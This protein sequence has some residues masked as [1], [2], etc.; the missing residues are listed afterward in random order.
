MAQSL[1]RSAYQS[2]GYFVIEGIKIGVREID[3][4]AVRLDSNS[5]VVERLHIEVQISSNPIGVLRD[6]SEFGETFK[7]P[8][9]SA[10]SYIQK[11]YNHKLIV[12]MIKSYFGKHKYCKVFVHGKLKRPDQLDVFRK[13]GIET[14]AISELV[15]QALKA[16]PVHELKRTMG[17]FGVL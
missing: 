5:S 12:N 3:L 8:Q 2:L 6:R 1:V 10:K 13:S 17:V 7:N 11:K 9:A 15:K 4:L 16:D 14:I